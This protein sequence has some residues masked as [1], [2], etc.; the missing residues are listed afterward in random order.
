[1][2][3][4]HAEACAIGQ[5]DHFL[6]RAFAKAFHANNS[7]AL[8]VLQGAGG[9]LGCACRSFVNQHNQRQVFDDSAAGHVMTLWLAAT[10][11][12]FYHHAF[13]L[14][15]RHKIH[16]T[17]QVSS[18]VVAQVDDESFQRRGIDRRQKFANFR[19]RLIAKLVD[20]EVADTSARSRFYLV[21]RTRNRDV[22]ALNSHRQY[23]AR[24]LT[25]DS[26]CDG[27]AFG[28]AN[29]CHHFIE[30]HTRNVFVVNGQNKILRQ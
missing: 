16:C 25:A 18:A 13:F 10:S 15:H 6:D 2:G 14:E 29:F 12:N 26:Q 1:M 19:N 9:N 27:C 24:T 21:F 3:N 23:F 7:R 8:A 28:A 17:V 20:G 22:I 4:G 30:P 11:G 5:I